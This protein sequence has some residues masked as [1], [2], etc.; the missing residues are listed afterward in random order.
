MEETEI[1]IE[2]LGQIPELVEAAKTYKESNEKIISTM[3][4]AIKTRPEAVIL[5]II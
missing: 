5:H 2:A 1:L 3:S 4:T